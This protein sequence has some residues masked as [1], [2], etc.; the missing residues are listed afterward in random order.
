MGEFSAAKAP[1]CPVPGR[2]IA[3]RH[4]YESVRNWLRGLRL[5]FAS[6]AGT[7]LASFVLVKEK[8]VVRASRR[9]WGGRRNFL[10]GL[11]AVLSLP[12]ALWARVQGTVVATAYCPC[13]ECCGSNSPESG[14][15]GLTASG[16]PPDPG[17]TVAADWRV[18]P[19][20][21]RL[22]IQDLGHRVVQDRGGRI[23]GTRI[24]VFFRAHAE[25]VAFG[26]RR[27]KVRVVR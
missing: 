26:R 20:G 22:L 15:H 21:T 27:V 5:P 24:D 2:K 16:Q 7:P 13:A 12:G 3:C 9:T 8:P 19:V 18:F 23:I 6:L 1:G 10:L 17:V 11:L 25:A 14:G 4:L